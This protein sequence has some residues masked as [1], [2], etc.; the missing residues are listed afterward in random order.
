M[1][2]Q[3]S[4][5]E[6]WRVDLNPTRGREQNGVRPCLVL[7][8]DKFNHGPA[9]LVVILPITS[10]NKRIPSHVHV[11]QGEGGTREDSYIKCEEVRCIS[12]DRLLD[13]WGTVDFAIMQKVEYHV[14]FI[15][16]L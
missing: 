5:G 8:V 9:D 15:L 14:R 2:A 16:G 11:Q 4:R 13:C 6:I 1:P 10:K 7:S 12:K 3:P